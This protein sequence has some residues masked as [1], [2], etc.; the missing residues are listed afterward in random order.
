M[1]LAELAPVLSKRLALVHSQFVDSAEE[2]WRKV[3]FCSHVILKQYLPLGNTHTSHREERGL[4]TILFFSPHPV[5]P[6]ALSS[7]L[8]AAAALCAT[9]LLIDVALDDLAM[10]EHMA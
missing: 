10:F 8:P 5:P 9:W 1:L 4:K 6:H 3:S 7:S 2:K